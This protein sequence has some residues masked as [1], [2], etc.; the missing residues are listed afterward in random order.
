MTREEILAVRKEFRKYLRTRDGITG[1][2]LD[3][4]IK[5]AEEYVPDLVREQFLPAFSGLYE[6][7]L[8]LAEL[9]RLSRRIEQND[10]LMARRQG[11]A[12]QRAVKSYAYFYAF[13]NGLNPDDYI[14]EDEPEYPIPDE[15]LTFQEG[16][17]YESRGIRYERDRNARCQCIEYYKNL[18]RDHKCRCQVCGMSFEDV[19][20]DIGKDFIE[21]HHLVPISLRGGNYEINPSKDLI[22]LCSN[23]HAMIHKGNVSVEELRLRFRTQTYMD[24]Q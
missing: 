23:C 18:D 2:D 8:G 13:K 14:L 15:S 11:Y 22:P 4:L 19:Y 7:K 21:V 1:A 20:G 9:L 3:A 16:T 17:E 24:H 10:R 5:A 6:D 12:C